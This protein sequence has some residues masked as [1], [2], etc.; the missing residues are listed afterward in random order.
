MNQ[1]IK[2]GPLKIQQQSISFE[3]SMYPIVSK[4]FQSR[5]LDTWN[6][7]VFQIGF[8][9]AGQYYKSILQ[10]CLWWEEFHWVNI[11]DA[12]LIYCQFPGPAVHCWQD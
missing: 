9:F 4:R 12:D 1:I 3:M 6:M 2:N 10:Q 8:G 7:N 11:I 5:T